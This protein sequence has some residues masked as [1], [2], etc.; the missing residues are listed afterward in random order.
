M[1]LRKIVLLALLAVVTS[2][3]GESATG[4]AS[5]ITVDTR[6]QAE[7]YAMAGD[8][9]S[10]AP[11]Y[12]DSSAGLHVSVMKVYTTALG[13]VVTNSLVNATPDADG[14]AAL[15]LSDGE[16]RRFTFIHQVIDADNQVV[17]TL[18]KQV[19]VGFASTAG[20]GIF[21][22]TTTNSIE[23]L[24]GNGSRL[25]IVYSTD[26]VTEGTSASVRITCEQARYRRDLLAECTTSVVYSASAPADG[27]L[28]YEFRAGN[29]GRFTFRCDFLDSNG[30][31]LG[32][33][34]TALARWEETWGLRILLR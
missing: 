10:Y 26:W 19:S 24:V 31:P 2:G 7:W 30:D 16:P 32:E 34:L 21:C 14:T 29:G 12:V 1:T 22:D 9:F 5:V 20:T 23:Y 11:Y 27:T 33:S 4:R 17:G 25:P 3:Y 28:D 15:T 6:G 18:E 13:V 8:Q